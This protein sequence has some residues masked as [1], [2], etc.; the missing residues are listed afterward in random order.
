[1]FTWEEAGQLRSMLQVLG[2]LLIL[3]I[4]AIIAFVLL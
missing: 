3:L 1:M 2:V 4:G